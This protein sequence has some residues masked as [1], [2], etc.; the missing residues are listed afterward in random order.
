MSARSSQ[1]LA[2]DLFRREYA[3]LVAVLTARFGPAHLESIEE[4]VQEAF[5][6]AIR[7]WE[8]RGV[9]DNAA[10]WLHT[11]A[12]NKALNRLR[13]DRR[14][15][16]TTGDA[17]ELSR[18]TEFAGD[19]AVTADFGAAAESPGQYEPAEAGEIDEEIQDSLL[20]MMF[21]C[22]H[23]GLSADSRVALIL[24]TLCGFSIDEIAAAFLCAPAAIQKRLVRARKT[25]RDLEISIELPTAAELPGRLGEVLTALYLLFNEGYKGSQSVDDSQSVAGAIMSSDDL[26]RSRLIRRELCEEALRLLEILKRSELFRRDPRLYACAALMR[27]NAARF[28][29]RQ[30]ANG[31]IVRMADQDRSLWD[32]DLIAR[33]IAELEFASAGGEI[34]TYHVQAA[35]SAHHCAAPDYAST[36]W[37][38]ILGLYDAWLQLE[39]T[40][41]IRLNRA[42]ALGRVHGG[43]AAIRELKALADEPAFRDYHLYETTLGELYFEAGRRDLA[44]SHFGAGLKLASTPAER[45]LL[46]RRIAECRDGDAAIS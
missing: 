15:A 25:L 14:L 12:R 43:P 1:E 6:E 17:L 35:I 18:E 10:A 40:P 4:A 46:S 42:I 29:A 27:L 39:D 45:R 26:S 3:K 38:A 22:C 2:E 24:K 11:V 36:D 13:Q 19:L 5:L 33:G 9:P 34:S 28:D 20:R 21:V 30:D 32:R 23:P 16:S 37:P 44:L 41:L 7:V 31:E 8:Y